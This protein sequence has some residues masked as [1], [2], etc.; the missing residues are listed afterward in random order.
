MLAV[1][2]G[3]GSSPIPELEQVVQRVCIGSKVHSASRAVE[4]RTEALWEV[5]R[6][7]LSMA[8]QDALLVPPWG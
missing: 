4:E 1:L 5:R 8:A 6:G 7:V 2:Q 3:V